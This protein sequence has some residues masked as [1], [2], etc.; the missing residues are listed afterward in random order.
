ME[1][2]NLTV[3]QLS[4]KVLQWRKQARKFLQ[5]A[6]RIQFFS[7]LIIVSRMYFETIF[8]GLSFTYSVHNLLR[9]IL[10]SLKF[11]YSEKATKFRTNF[12]SSINYFKQPTKKNP[13]FLPYLLKSGQIN[14]GTKFHWFFW[15]IEDKKRF[16]WDF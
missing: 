4:S 13:I 1:F 16:F 8:S 10:M 7:K 12:L 14:K 6:N 2:R 11:R 15:G 5:L 3:M 9:T